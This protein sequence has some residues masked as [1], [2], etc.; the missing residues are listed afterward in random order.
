MQYTTRALSRYDQKDYLCLLRQLTAVGT[1]SEAL[2]NQIYEEIDDSDN[3]EIF[4]MVDEEDHGHLVAAGTLMVE[5]KFIHG[6]SKV[7]HIE[8]IVVSHA[9]RGQGLG[10]KM[11]EFLSQRAKDL[12]AYKVILDCK[13]ELEGFYNKAGFARNEIQMRKNL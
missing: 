12:G 7:G 8:D 11:V 10:R 3:I 1:Y 2:W 4:V 6:G 5:Q 9:V 13:E